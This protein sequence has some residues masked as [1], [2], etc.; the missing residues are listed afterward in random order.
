MG[1][2]AMMNFKKQPKD[3]STINWEHVPSWLIDNMIKYEKMPSKGIP[4][5][6]FSSGPWEPKFFK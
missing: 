5:F 2:N 3:V 4:K 1:Y 6:L